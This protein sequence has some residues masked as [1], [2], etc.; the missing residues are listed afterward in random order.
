MIET[1]RI[2][3]DPVWGK[4]VI[5]EQ[6]LLE[7]MDSPEMQRTK[8]ISQMGVPSE[9]HHLE[10][11]FRFDHMIG[12][13]LSIFKINGSLSEKIKALTHDINHT[14]FSHLP[15]WINE[16]EGKQD[17]QDDTL[18]KFL[19]RSS[20]PGILDKYGFDIEDFFKE[21]DFPLSE[22]E[23][24]KLCADRLD[25]GLREMSVSFKHNEMV[26]TCVD[27]LTTFEGRMVFGNSY[28]AKTFGWGFLE[29]WDNDWN[30]RQ[31][32][33][34][35][36]L[37]R[38]I[39]KTGLDREVISWDDFKIDDDFVLNKINLSKDQSL[40]DRLRNLKLPIDQNPD[41]VTIKGH[42]PPHKFRWVD[43][44]F[45]TNNG[46]IK[47]TEI[48]DFYKNTIAQRMESAKQGY[49]I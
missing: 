6:V 39:L 42:H 10:V 36:L 15:D 19:R 9:Q 2:I 38:D 48:D 18:S 33:G 13:M 37:F 49:V 31:S 44:E 12:A 25:Y 23:A 29:L 8:G 40:I 24:P 21:E 34:Q 26:R 14:A 27:S 7:I 5:S 20:I 4:A 3:N 28:A 35:H 30:S 16:R 32:L 45:M 1:P 41:L 46:L 43:P 22:Q 47:L 17:F 11:L